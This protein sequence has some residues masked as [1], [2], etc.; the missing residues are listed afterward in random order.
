MRPELASRPAAG[1]APAE[2]AAGA[3]AP[4]GSAG[5]ALALE[6]LVVYL[7]LQALTV[8]FLPALRS[9]RESFYDDVLLGFFGPEKH[10]LARLLRDGFLPTW[11]DNQYGGEPF[12]ANLQ[13]AVLYPGNL[14]FWFLPTSTA[15][16]VVAA[17]HV[18]LAGTFMWSYCR[19]ALRTGW[20]GAA[21]A[22]LAFGFGSITLQHI[23][24][25]NQLQVIAWMP[26][27]LL[28]GHLALD[29]AGCGGWC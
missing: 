15:L 25:L 20:A 3:P 24:L 17:L 27:V 22:G 21:L 7:V 23:I 16:E 29:R 9:A 8:P 13:H 28:F 18:A 6:G 10:G 19:L 12:L 26:L 4:A 14:P 5:R 11:L 1:P 2:P